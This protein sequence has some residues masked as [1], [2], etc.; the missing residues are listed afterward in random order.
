M[1]PF[2]KYESLLSNTDCKN[3]GKQKLQTHKSQNY[4]FVLTKLYKM[5]SDN[6]IASYKLSHNVLPLM[7]QTVNTL[8]TFF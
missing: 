6:M 2:Y 4:V 1:L 7:S 8:K 5:M 3:K